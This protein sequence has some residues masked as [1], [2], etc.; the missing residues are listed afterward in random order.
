MKLVKA[1]GENEVI[2]ILKRYSL[3]DSEANWNILGEMENNFS[4]IGNQQS[5]ADS[6][7]VEKLIN[8]IDAMLMKECLVSDIDPESAEAPITMSIAAEQFF[9]I[10]SGTLVNMS[11]TK[12]RKLAENIILMATGSRQL[13]SYTIIDRGEGQ[14]PSCFVD[15]FLSLAK[16]NKIKIPF[17]QGKFNSG[18]TGS[19]QFCGNYGLQ[20]IVS[21][22]DPKIKRD[23]PTKWG[24][25]IIRKFSPKTGYKSSQYRYLVVDG[26]IPTFEKDY[27]SVMPGQYPEAYKEPLISGTLIKMYDYNIGPSLRTNI[28]L[29]LYN[30]LSLLMPTVALPILLA[31]RRTGYSG[32]SLET[33]LSGL[34]VRLDE[35]KN[36]NL[37]PGFPDSGNIRINGQDMGV[38]IYAF[39]PDSK[40]NYSTTEGIIFLINGQTHGSIPNSFFAR[41]SVD[42][43]YLKNSLLVS[44]DCSFIDTESREQLIMNSR[45]RLRKTDFLIKIEESLQEMLKEHP[46]LRALKESRRREELTDIIGDSKPVKEVLNKVITNSP[47]LSSVLKKGKGG[48][49]N[50]FDLRDSSSPKDFEGKFFPTY[51]NIKEHKTVADAKICHINRKFRLEAFTDAVN[52]Y[53]ERD[54]SPGSYNML[55]KVDDGLE[56]ISDYTL[57]LWNG[58]CNLSVNLPNNSEVG[59]INEYTFEVYD[60]RDVDPFIIRFYV[61]V[62]TP[63]TSSSDTSGKRKS[64][65]GTPGKG[66]SATKSELLLPNIQEVYREKWT[67]HGFDK[68]SSMDIVETEGQMDIFVNMENIFLLSEIKSRY[69]IE[70]EVIKTQYKY[71]LALFSISYFSLSQDD[72]MPDYKIPSQAFSMIVIPMLHELNNL[73]EGDL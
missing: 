13:P 69:G 64:S 21:R 34:T 29:D 41:K 71:A 60:D 7:L 55:I 57:H 23:N 16:T 5:E 43:S 20:L 3:W 9:K 28:L 24:F 4:I 50:P 27:I 54:V 12:R 32:H 30:R 8:S 26:K 22:R 2:E 14:D 42:L 31:E 47:L 37:E 1:D 49:Q 17:V 11:L 48:V 39:K 40:R 58:V 46:G 59:D 10:N 72:E 61:K 52:D 33:V 53:F 44:L 63:D 51:F 15:T 25:T 36:K 68:Y 62:V 56:L 45:D 73:S 38:K 67:E 70:A 19:L 65:D 6:A 35:D 66:D 18:G